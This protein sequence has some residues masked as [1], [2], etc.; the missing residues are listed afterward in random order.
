M[1]KKPAFYLL[2]CLITAIG[3]AVPGYA[4][5]ASCGVVLEVENQVTG[6]TPSTEEVFVFVLTAS[7]A[8]PMPEQDTVSMKGAGSSFFSSITYTHPGDYHYTLTEKPGSATGY[9]YDKA[10]Y[11]VTV[12][13]ITDSE[14]QLHA[15]LYLAKDG[16]EGK[17]A[18]ALFVNQYQAGGPEDSPST[19]DPSDLSF[20]LA[21][22]GISLTGLLVTSFLCQK[23]KKTAH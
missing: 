12:Q 20:W 6:D 1:M 11:R 10:V 22:S 13:V 23:K 14:G 8:A 17:P 7:D 18:S 15:T 4:E 16:S 19:G 9:T 3:L 2:L 21:L 5:E